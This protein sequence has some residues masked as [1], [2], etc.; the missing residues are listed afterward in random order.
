MIPELVSPAGSVE[1]LEY[2]YLYGADAAYIGVD[3]FSLRSR[4]D[5]V[6][7]GTPEIIDAIKGSRKLYG[8]LNA[9]FHDEDLDRLEEVSESIRCFPFDALIVSDPGAMSLIR[10]V[11]PQH[12]L[13][14]S[15]QANCTNS[16]S[17]KFYRDLG[18]KRI[19]LGRELTLQQLER[20]RNSVPDVELEVFVHG[21]MCIAYSGRCYLSRYMTGRSANEGDCAHS[22][23][24]EYRVLEEGK[25][26]G[27]YYPVESDDRFTTIFSSKD[28]CMFDYI[29]RLT[30]IGIDAFKI[31]G[32]MKSLYYTAVT[33]AAYKA[34]ISAATEDENRDISIFRKELDRV[35]HREY[36]TGFYTGEPEAV[37]P[38][39][40]EYVRNTLFLGTVN[41]EEPDGIFSLNV[42]NQIRLGQAID[43]I[44]PNFEILTDSDY[45]LLDEHSRKVEKV[46]H[47]KPSY[48]RTR[49]PIQKGTIIRQLRDDI[50]NSSEIR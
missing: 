22:C 45:V 47:G 16:E 17:A 30:D 14:L 8:A 38:T 32:R 33:S 35:S 25:R 41:A 31:E 4:A 21:A 6:D 50:G 10:R 18:F 26:P 37:E 34:A 44:T 24:W 42:K 1:K 39:D 13:H 15:T 12:Q 2:S 5:T 48:L 49:H 46:D 40:S 20:I 9:Y 36:S 19:I 7:D 23:R 3:R 27:E 43:F 28:L 11:F 29:P